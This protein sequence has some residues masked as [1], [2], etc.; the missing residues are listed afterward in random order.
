MSACRKVCRQTGTTMLHGFIRRR[1]IECVFIG[2]NTIFPLAELFL[3]YLQFFKPITSAYSAH[4]NTACQQMGHSEK[5]C[6]CTWQNMLRILLHQ[7]QS[8][9]FGLLFKRSRSYR[10]AGIWSG[11][12]SGKLHS[13]VVYCENIK[14]Y[15]W[16]K[17]THLFGSRILIRYCKTTP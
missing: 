6:K 15:S 12:I 3:F 7:K 2:H 14:K 10:D 8:K 13:L 11:R 17:I 9:N 1:N 5:A 4:L 16:I